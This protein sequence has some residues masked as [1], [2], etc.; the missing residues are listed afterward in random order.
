M[1]ARRNRLIFALFLIATPFV[2]SIVTQ[3]WRD[4]LQ[5]VASSIRFGSAMTQVVVSHLFAYTGEAIGA[6]LAAFILAV[7]LAWLIRSRPFLLA[8][9]LLGACCFTLLPD[10]I[11]LSIPD[12]PTDFKLFVLKFIA[13]KARYLLVFFVFCYVASS[14]IVKRIGKHAA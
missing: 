8:S 2:Y 12:A 1:M 11:S 9:C 5:P 4:L 13:L 10:I 14:L 3:S 6:C 7:P